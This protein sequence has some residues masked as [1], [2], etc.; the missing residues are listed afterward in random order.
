MSHK[1]KLTIILEA[2]TSKDLWIWQTFF[3]MPDSHNDINLLQRSPIF[4]RLV[5]GQDPQVK[6]CINEN[7]YSMS[8]YLADG[9]YPSWTTF[10]KS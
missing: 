9:I 6:Y 1:K 5:E 8:Y 4:A 3:G 7:D 10:V 2:V